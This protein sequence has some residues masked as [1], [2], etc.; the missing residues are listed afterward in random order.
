MAT[1]FPEDPAASVLKGKVLRD[2]QKTW[3]FISILLYSFSF[4]LQ[5][6]FVYY[7]FHSTFSLTLFPFYYGWY[8][9]FCYIYTFYCISAPF[10]HVA[11]S[12]H[13]TPSHTYRLSI[14]LL[15]ISGPVPVFRPYSGV[16]LQ[17]HYI[18]H[19]TF[20]TTLKIETARF[21]EMLFTLYTTRCHVN[22]TKAVFEK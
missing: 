13:Y 20:I 12:Q 2:S 18:P 9:C 21:S 14:Y 4:S 11:S 8:I 5:S 16:I 7:L 6:F 3:L 22:E 17:G 19:Y 1:D 10:S 15:R